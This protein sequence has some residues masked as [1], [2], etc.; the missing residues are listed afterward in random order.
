MNTNTLP[1]DI[2]SEME[3]SF[4]RLPFGFGTRWLKPI[5]KWGFMRGAISLYHSGL[6]VPSDTYIKLMEDK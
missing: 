2:A 6:M 3:I 4:D 1:A 5:A